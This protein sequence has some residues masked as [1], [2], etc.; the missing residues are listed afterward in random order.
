VKK[1]DTEEIVFRPGEVRGFLCNAFDQWCY[2]R[3]DGKLAA[4]IYTVRLAGGSNDVKIKVT[5]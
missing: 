3:K 4:G 1:H 5:E 2:R